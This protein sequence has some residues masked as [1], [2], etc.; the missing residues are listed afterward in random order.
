MP[1]LSLSPVSVSLAWTLKPNLLDCSSDPDL[2]GEL[3]SIRLHLWLPF[4]LCITPPLPLAHRIAHHWPP[5]T[6]WTIS[7]NSAS[8]PSHSWPF[9]LPTTAFFLSLNLYRIPPRSQRPPQKL[10]SHPR[11]CLYSPFIH[12][13]LY[14]WQACPWSPSCMCTAGT[15]PKFTLSFTTNLLDPNDH[16]NFAFITLA[17]LALLPNQLIRTTYPAYTFPKVTFD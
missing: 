1:V 5:N 9:S 7:L 16:I 6:L 17:S 14:H 2:A 12:R 4:S 11:P 15:I 8:P 10:I 13:A 3:P